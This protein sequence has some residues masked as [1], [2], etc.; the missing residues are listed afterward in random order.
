MEKKISTVNFGTNICW[1][2][3][4]SSSIQWG[5]IRIYMFHVFDRHAYDAT[6]AHSTLFHLEKES[7]KI[8]K[9]ETML[10]MRLG[11]WNGQFVEFDRPM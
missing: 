10:W 9:L 6:L 8:E 7:V 2:L 4:T 11:L 5:G 3:P 1:Q